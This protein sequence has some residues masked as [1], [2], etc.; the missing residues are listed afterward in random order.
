MIW[1]T[2][3]SARFSLRFNLSDRVFHFYV[4][5]SS[6]YYGCA[7]TSSR[8]PSPPRGLISKNFLHKNERE[9]VK[10]TKFISRH[11]EALINE[12]T[13]QWIIYHFTGFSLSIFRSFHFTLWVN[14]RN[15][16]AELT[17]CQERRG[18]RKIR[19]VVV[20]CKW[21]QFSKLFLYHH[22]QKKMCETEGT[23]LLSLIFLSSGIFC[24]WPRFFFMMLWNF[25]AIYLKG[26][27]KII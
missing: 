20:N 14:K 22:Q 12:I 15:K 7:C 23:Q 2:L 3:K 9:F 13:K 6:R 11:D 10:H 4:F 18:G 21:I 17:N 8:L 16:V 24:I 5:K 27:W 26:I 19:V 1:S 25:I